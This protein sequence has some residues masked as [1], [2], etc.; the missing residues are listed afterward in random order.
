MDDI[1]HINKNIIINEL[2][3]IYIKGIKDIN[4]YDSIEKYLN[5]LNINIKNI[6]VKDI[7]IMIILQ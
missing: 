6:K 3:F 2:Y 1:P 4:I 5:I 7:S